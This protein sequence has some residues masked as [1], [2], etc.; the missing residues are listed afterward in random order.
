MNIGQSVIL[1]VPLLPLVTPNLGA[2]LGLGP[3]PE[4][5]LIIIWG[6]FGSG[7]IFTLI[8]VQSRMARIPRVMT[9]T[10]I[11]ALNT[12]YIRMMWIHYEYVRRITLATG[13]YCDDYHPITNSLPYHC[14][15][16]TL[17][18]PLRRYFT[19]NYNR[20]TFHERW[21]MPRT[22]QNIVRMQD[23]IRMTVSDSTTNLCELKT[24]GYIVSSQYIR[25]LMG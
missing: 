20:E 14:R 18:F 2:I 17:P 4:Q 22:W 9:I 1:T 5:P 21:R 6:R 15:I 13:C 23:D 24:M 25:A 10:I 7:A 8:T 3:W 11:H 16:M 12:Y 19:C